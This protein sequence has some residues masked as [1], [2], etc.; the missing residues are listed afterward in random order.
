M[1]ASPGHSPRHILPSPSPSITGIDAGV[2]HENGSGLLVASTPGRSLMGPPPPK[3]AKR[4]QIVVDEDAYVA[5]IEKIIERDF[6]PDIP[7][8]QNRLEWLEAVRSADPVVIRE[9]QLNIIQRMKGKQK[10]AE[11]DGT[12]VFPGSAF[13]TPGS[14]MSGAPSPA[15][16]FASL[17][18]ISL[19]QLPSQASPTE[20]PELDTAMSLDEFMRSYTSED[21]A[22]FSKIIEKVNKQKREKYRFLSDKEMI[23]LRLTSGDCE[24]RI[25]DGYGTSGQPASTLDTWT[26][27]AKNLLMYDSAERADAPLTESEKEEKV[28]GPPKVINMQNTRFHGK[29]F[30]SKLREEDAVSILYTPVPGST[31]TAWAF[32]ERDTDKGR[33]RYDLEE[34]RRT[35]Q[36]KEIIEAGRRDANPPLKG[37]AGYSFVATPSP[38]PGVDESP[39]MTWGEIEGTPLRLEMEDTPVGIGGSGD[40]PHFKIPAPPTRDARAHTLSRDAARSLREKSRIYQGG[41]SPSPARG[42]MSPGLGVLSAA[43]QRFVS[44]AMAKS[45]AAVDPKLR[46]SYGAS[47]TPGTPRMARNAVRSR[48]GSSSGREGSILL[49]SPSVRGE[50][51]PLRSPS[52]SPLRV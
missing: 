14:V 5:A 15:P 38:A 42:S 12:P 30:D 47:T 17:S 3:R 46:A 36:V 20:G 24:N 27:Q 4:S 37:T 8:L 26:Y 16:S 28:Q 32:A 2:D 11:K 34:L 39:F 44:K 49:R 10:A 23:E 33:K 35:P 41:L 31:P 29:M 50:S 9:A 18:N 40:G 21:N 45:C 43:A 48:E 51:I 7:K 22:S 52:A 6:Y 13:P 1:L 19:S 25:T